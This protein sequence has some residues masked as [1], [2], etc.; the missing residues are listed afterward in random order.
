MSWMNKYKYDANLKISNSWNIWLECC[1][2]HNR[3]LENNSL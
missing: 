1:F 2:L 3:P